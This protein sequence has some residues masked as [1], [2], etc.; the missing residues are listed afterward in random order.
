MKGI[1]QD[2]TER[3]KAEEE[4]RSLANIMGSSN[5]AIITTS[6]DG[7]ITSWNKGAE[8][9]YG[10]P[11]EEIIGKSVSVLAPDN[12]KDET[13]TLIEKV[14]LGEKIQHYVTSR[15]R[16]D[17]KLI[18]V[19]IVLSPVLDAS[20]ELVA[21][22]AIARDITQRLEAEKSLVKAEKNRKK[23]IHHRIKNNLQ[24]ISSLLDLQARSLKIESVSK[25]RKFWKLSEKAK[26]E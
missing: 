11:S 13:K 19:S 2:I 17:D 7:I 8:K 22:S 15:L 26:I 10:Y 25:I 16:K 14:K 18:Y 6:L 24:V 9:I 4:I 21:I 1:V 12:L 20:R 23:E 3:K 5:D